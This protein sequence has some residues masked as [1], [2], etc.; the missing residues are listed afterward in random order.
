M[1]TTTLGIIGFV[2]IGVVTI[3]GIFKLRKI[4]RQNREALGK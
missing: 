2:F 1:T 4:E 3:Y